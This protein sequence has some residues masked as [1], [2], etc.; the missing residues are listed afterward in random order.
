LNTIPDK[1]HGKE[2]QAVYKALGDYICSKVPDDC[3][4]VKESLKS[5]YNWEKADGDYGSADEY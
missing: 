2:N 4:V 5:M 1:K 3:S